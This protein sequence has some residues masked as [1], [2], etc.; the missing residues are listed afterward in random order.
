[1]RSESNKTTRYKGNDCTLLYII[2]RY[3]QVDV[4]SIKAYSTHISNT[5]CECSVTG[6]TKIC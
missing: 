5:E 2:P 1:M 3:M 4:T 6:R